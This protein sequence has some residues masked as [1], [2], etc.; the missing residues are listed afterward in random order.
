MAGEVDIFTFLKPRNIPDNIVNQLKDDR[1]DINVINVMT[2]EELGKY[3]ERYGDRLA[4]RAFC[5]QRTGTN[6]MSGERTTVKSSLMQKIRDRLRGKGEKADPDVGPGVGN[7]HA[8]KDTRRVE[9]GWLNFEKGKYYQ[10]CTRHGG[11]TRHMSV[12]KT[13]TME[14]LLDI[15]KA[16][17][18]P[19]GKS[20]KGPLKDFKFDVRDFSH[21]PVPLENTV[22]QL[23]DQTKLRMLRIYTCS[24]EKDKEVSPKDATIMLSDTSS[25]FERT[26]HRPIKEKAETVCEEPN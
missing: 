16:L 1:I 23:Y 13:V 7:K 11:G 14:E 18:F 22:Q 26:D 17:F 8:S 4:L 9:I 19:N 6:E 10:V 15:G 2:A 5:R 20:A 21:C 24:K 25:D 3:I 12:E